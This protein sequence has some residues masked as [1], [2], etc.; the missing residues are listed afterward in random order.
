M[1]EPDADFDTTYRPLLRQAVA[2]IAT[3]ETQAGNDAVALAHEY[4]GRGKP[5]FTLAFLLAATLDDTEKREI[6]AT[7]YEQRAQLTAGKAKE[8]ASR[9]ARDFPLLVT[10]ATQ[11]RAIARQVRAGRRI[12]PGAGRQLPRSH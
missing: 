1:P 8:L 7:A 2:E 11:D 4:A 5:D 3:R 12:I 9:F 10:D 6:F